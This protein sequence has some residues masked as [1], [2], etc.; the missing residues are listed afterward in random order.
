MITP[1]IAP[2]GI[3]DSQ[4]RVDQIKVIFFHI[5]HILVDFSLPN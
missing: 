3:G 5:V 2:H 1:L 4:V